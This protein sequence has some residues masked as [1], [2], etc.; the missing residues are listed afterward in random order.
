M[1]ISLFQSMPFHYLPGSTQG[2]VRMLVKGAKRVYVLY[3]EENEVYTAIG[4]VHKEFPIEFFRDLSLGILV[5]TYTEEDIKMENIEYTLVNLTQH[6]I[7]IYNEEGEH[8]LTVPPSGIEARCSENSSHMAV[9]NGIPVAHL[10]LGE[11]EG[12]PAPKTGTFYIVSLLTAVRAREDNLGRGDLLVTGKIMRDENGRIVGCVGLS[13]IMDNF[14]D[15][16]Y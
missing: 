3:S 12:L 4:V 2:D 5:G 9:V 1:S 15:F 10:K 16:L 8:V 6:N 13:S 14:P 11:V 7:D